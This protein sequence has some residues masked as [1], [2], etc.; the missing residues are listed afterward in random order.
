MPRPPYSVRPVGT[1]RQRSTSGGRTA[2]LSGEGPWG[3]QV[4]EL[5]ET[6]RATGGEGDTKGTWAHTNCLSKC[7][8]GP[9]VPMVNHMGTPH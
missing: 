5:I 2:S 8:R 7:L 9:L 1:P 6:A 4:S 3:S